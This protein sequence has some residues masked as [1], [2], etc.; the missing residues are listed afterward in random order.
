MPKVLLN[1][2]HSRQ[3]LRADCLPSCV[4]MVLDYFNRPIAYSRLISLLGAHDFGTPAENVVR[5]EDLGIGVK[6]TLPHAD[7]H[8]LHRHLENDRPVIAFVNTGDLP[9]WSEATDHAV[10]VVGMDDDV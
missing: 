8:G 10:V 3:R 4:A 5:L 1:V 6:V 9:Y 7:V 2:P